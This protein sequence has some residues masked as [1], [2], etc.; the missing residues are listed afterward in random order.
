MYSISVILPVYNGIKYLPQSV[1]SV[2][3]QQY[4][5]FEFLVID[6][7]STD[8]SWEYLNGLDDNRIGLYRNEKNCGL[9]YNLNFLIKRCNSPIIKIWAQDDIMYPNCLTE[10]VA[11]HKLYPEIGFSYTERD[12]IDADGVLLA[13][14]EKDD[15]P[16]I[17]STEM[18]AKIAFTAGSIAGNICNVSIN[19]VVLDQVG[20]FNEQMKICGDFEMWVRLAKNHPVGFIKTPLVQFRN[21]KEQLSGQEKYFIYH[22]KEDVQA[23]DILLNY[24]SPVQQATGRKLLRNNKLIFYYILMLKALLKGNIATAYEFYK[25]LCKLDNFYLITWSFLKK[26]ITG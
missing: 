4:N 10:I 5:N 2:L 25:L 24:L 3:N 14:R 13:K 23:Y 8:G 20:L 17:I 19:K 11:F 22:L 9:F 7:C 16:T 12:F 6:D 1:R 21:H 26:K 15:T 18:H